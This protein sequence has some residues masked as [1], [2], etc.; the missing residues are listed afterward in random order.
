MPKSTAEKLRA[1]EKLIDEHLAFQR[2]RPDLPQANLSELSENELEQ[3]VTAFQL[4]KSEQGA[5]G[6]IERPIRLH[7]P[8]REQ[9]NIERRAGAEPVQRFLAGVSASRWRCTENG[10]GHLSDGRCD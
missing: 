2:G 7:R 9:K 6:Q 5:L 10:S 4:H 1:L 3:L 8:E